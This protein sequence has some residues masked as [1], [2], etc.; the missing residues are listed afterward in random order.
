MKLQVEYFNF[1]QDF[2]ED[3]IRCIPMI[4]RFK[5]DACG[6]KLKLKEWSKMN[7]GERENLANYSIES[8]EQLQK[9]QMYLEGLI[10]NYTGHK[11]TY[12]ANDQ[13]NYS[14]LLTDQLPYQVQSKLVELKMNLSIGQWKD[15]SVLKR[16][17]LL[18]LTRPGHENKNFPKAMIE[19]GLV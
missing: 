2:M 13:Q 11:P 16:Y 17:A 7:L 4:V 9:Y 6:I 15:L 5:L 10:L 18:K 1:E 14:W 3:N 8:E 19:F 12:L